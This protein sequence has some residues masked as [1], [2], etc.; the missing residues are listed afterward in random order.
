MKFNWG[1]GILIFLILFLLACTVFIVFAF[2][3]DVNLVHKNY[4]EKGVDYTEQMNIEARSL[5]Y[6]EAITLK[7]E[8]DFIRLEIE[9]KLATIIDSGNV[10]LYRPSNSKQ[11]ILF[12]V[13]KA[14]KEVK[15]PKGDL[16]HGRYILKFFWYSE[17][18]KYEIGQVVNIQ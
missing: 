17:G 18:L 1:T 11:D 4:Y 5:K 6:K 8:N 2:N 10:L 13:E 16:I 9:A 15:I 3:Q 12:P 14:V 7:S